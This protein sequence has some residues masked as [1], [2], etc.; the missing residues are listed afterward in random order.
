MDT[1]ISYSAICAAFDGDDEIRDYCDPSIED[2]TPKGVSEDVF[3]K[4]LDYE[5]VVDGVFKTLIVNGEEVGFVYY[6]DSILVSFG[7]NK[8]HRSKEF[9]TSLFDDMRS[10]LGDEFI[11]YMWERNARAVRWFERC[12]MIREEFELDNV[13]KLRYKKCL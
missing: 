10:W 6:F 11:T 7:V 8:T 12:G 2:S 3:K 4:L 5:D 9:L 1:K 13:I